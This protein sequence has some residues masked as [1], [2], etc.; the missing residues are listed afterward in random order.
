MKRH[1]ALVRIPLVIGAPVGAALATWATDQLPE[2]VSAWPVLTTI[3]VAFFVLFAKLVEEVLRSLINSSVGLRRLIL[4]RDFIEG[5]WV[6]QIER[7]RTM[8]GTSNTTGEDFAI[9]SIYYDDGD[10]VVEGH[11]LDP[12]GVLKGSWTSSFSTYKDGALEYIFSGPWIV[13]EEPFTNHG[14]GKISFVRNA[15]SK[16]PRYFNGEV[17]NI[18]PRHNQAYFT[19]TKVVRKVADRDI[20]DIGAFA[21]A[22]RDTVRRPAA[23]PSPAALPMPAG[24]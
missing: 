16:P 2:T 15:G 9:A 6:E 1:R 14:Y 10:Y 13:A 19:G 5:W 18:G 4:G 24:A 22:L 3:F 11:L 20:L 23:L 21:L 12:R 17:V 8:T 7:I